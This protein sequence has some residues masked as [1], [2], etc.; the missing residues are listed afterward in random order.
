MATVGSV[1]CRLGS[2]PAGMICYHNQTHFSLLCTHSLPLISPPL[3]LCLCST[4][5]PFASFL[6]PIWPS[7]E[8]K[9][10]WQSIYRKADWSVWVV[11]VFPKTHTIKWTQKHTLAL[12]REEGTIS[13]PARYHQGA[14]ACNK[15]KL[16]P[17]CGH[18]GK[19]LSC[20]CLIGP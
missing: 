4:L 13:H 9:F 7:F 6:L 16:C 19:L 20:R 5:F 18:W 8:N 15:V 3:S 2:D 10:F 12:T 1:L 11:G 17:E 14:V